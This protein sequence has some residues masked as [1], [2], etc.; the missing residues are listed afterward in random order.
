MFFLE[1]LCPKWKVNWAAYTVII[2]KLTAVPTARVTRKA[3]SPTFSTGLQL[4]G[5]SAPKPL[6]YPLHNLMV[7]IPVYVRFSQLYYYDPESNV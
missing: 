4:V 3:C 7:Y 1:D 6:A 5:G 2:Y